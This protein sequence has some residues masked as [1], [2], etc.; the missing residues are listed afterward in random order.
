MLGAFR[1]AALELD[2]QIEAIAG[3]APAALA[4]QFGRDMGAGAAGHLGHRRAGALVTEGVV[5]APLALIPV[6][7]VGEPRQRHRT[8]DDPP[9]LGEQGLGGLGIGIGA[10]RDGMAPPGG[11]AGQVVPAHPS[12]AHVEDGLGVIDRIPGRQGRLLA[13]LGLG[14]A[15]GRLLF[16]VGLL[17]LPDVPGGRGL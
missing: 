7:P 16:V 8:G 1:T 10:H 15:Q 11:G 13:M 2:R 6:R 12:E 4:V 9:R 5:G 3:A 14:L 17:V